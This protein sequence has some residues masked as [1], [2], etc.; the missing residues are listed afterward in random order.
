MVNG[1]DDF[2]RFL[3]DDRRTA[4]WRA[5]LSDGRVIVQDDGRPGM[6][7]ASAWLRLKS[8]L[9]EHSG[10]SLLSL[11]IQFR[12][13]HKKNILP[14]NA[15][16]YFFCKSEIGF[17]GSGSSQSFYLLGALQNGV[18]TVQKW[19]VPE[20]ILVET[21]VREIDSAGDCLILNP[22]P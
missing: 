2:T 13:H 15:S 7:P 9:Q 14:E 20:L 12:S 4:L 22:T 19:S 11:W 10:L 5:R 1:E 6:E 17:W 21:K 8:H 18:L 16:G 3:E